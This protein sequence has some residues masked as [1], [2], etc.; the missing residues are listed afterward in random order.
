MSI[1]GELKE[2]RN[3]LVTDANAILEASKGNMNDEQTAQFD[4]MYADADVIKGNIERAERAAAMDA[5]MRAS[6]APPPAAMAGKPVDT[7]AAKVAAHKAAFRDYLLNGAEM[8]TANKAVLAEHRAQTTTTT[9]GGY[10]IPSDLEREI[11]V[12]MLAY[13]GMRQAARILTTTS[14]NPLNWPTNNDTG[15]P[16]K[17]LNATTTP[18]TVDELDL[19]FG[20]VPFGA[21]TYTT[22]KI[23][24][25][26]ELLQ[27]SVFDLDT[28]IRDAFVTRI[29]RIQNTE[30]TLGTGTTM[31]NGVVPA[32]TTGVVGA[33]GETLQVT[34][35]SLVNLIH[36]LDVAYRPNAKF[37]FNDLFL[38]ACRKLTNTYGQPLLGLG[39]NGGDPD[40]ILGYKY[41]VNN[42]IAVPAID[43]KSALFGD[44]SKY[45]I[46][47]V[48]GISVHRLEELGALQNQTVFVAFSRADGQLVDAG[49]HP[50]VSYTQSHT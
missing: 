18:G 1:I 21:W 25:P 4:K 42:N 34:Y 46:R 23:S 48:A 30:F 28:F 38:S 14:G 12:A 13:G 45:I 17:R 8:S 5:E 33:V 27:D 41:V 35:A 31:P 39:I 2:K 15:N 44:F 32:V 9:G 7:E 37:M 26:N 29:G 19:T 36:K 40:S 43:A 6:V 3:K 10:L 16:G 20:T 22:Q 47:D 24:V 50:I 11:E 49:T